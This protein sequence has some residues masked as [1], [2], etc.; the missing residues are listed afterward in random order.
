MK[1]SVF[2]KTTGKVSC[3]QFYWQENNSLP[4]SVSVK[5]QKHITNSKKEIMANVGKIKLYL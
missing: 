1:K 2:N 3:L 4:W 5:L